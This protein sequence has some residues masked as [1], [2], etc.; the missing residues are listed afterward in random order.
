MYVYSSN[1]ER[2]DKKSEL[3]SS[4]SSSEDKL[5]AEEES[6]EP[7]ETLAETMKIKEWGVELPLK[8]NIKDV[9]YTFQGSNQNADGKPNTA[10]LG[11]KSLDKNGCNILANGPTKEA[12]PFGS[13]VRVPLKE[14]D[15]ITGKLYTEQ[16]PDGTVVG[17]NYYA[18]KSWANNKCTTPEKLKSIDTDFKL[19]A[20]SIAPDITVA[21]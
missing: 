3:T 19:S 15:P 7:K 4:Q 20:K 13:I 2:T 10:W 9:Y 6:A 1:K 17:E 12:T 21:D 11:I 14:V 18:Y 8:D 16:Y 5:N